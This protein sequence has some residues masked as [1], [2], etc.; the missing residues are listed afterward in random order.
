MPS[1]AKDAEYWR[2]HGEPELFEVDT[3]INYSVTITVPAYVRI[4]SNCAL[5]TCPLLGHGVFASITILA[6]ESLMRLEKSIFWITA[7]NVRA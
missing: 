2:W 3:E 4:G 5:A 6:K 7:L 1:G